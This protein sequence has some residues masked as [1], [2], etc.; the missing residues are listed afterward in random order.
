MLQV[1]EW[2]SCSKISF[3]Q[4]Q[5]NCFWYTWYLHG[6]NTCIQFL[7][8]ILFIVSFE[9]PSHWPAAPTTS[10]GH[11]IK[12]QPKFCTLLVSSGLTNHEQNC[13]HMLSSHMLLYPQILWTPTWPIV[14]NKWRQV[15]TLVVILLFESQ[16]THIALQEYEPWVT[17]HNIPEAKLSC[18]INQVSKEHRTPPINFIIIA[19]VC[20]YTSHQL[21][22][23]L[24]YYLA[25]KKIVR[26][27]NT[28]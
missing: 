22:V 13:P 3:Q 8:F 14:T 2:V 6:S 26:V 18:W 7:F 17:H 1:E 4:S 12:L 15:D 25:T 9:K 19:Y 21:R 28:H 23:P 10:L 27:T 24:Y 16:T 20:I 11:Q 5:R